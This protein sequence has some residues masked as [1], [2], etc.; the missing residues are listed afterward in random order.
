MAASLV[1][2][3]LPKLVRLTDQVRRRIPQNV[4]ALDLANVVREGRTP[5]IEGVLSARVTPTELAIEAMRASG[6][7]FGFFSRF[8]SFHLVD[9]VQLR[10]L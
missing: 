4:P 2:A 3:H 7:R 8:N 1:L 10:H 9:L 6:E 5:H